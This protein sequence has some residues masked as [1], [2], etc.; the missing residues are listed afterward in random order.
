[1]IGVE[2]PMKAPYLGTPKIVAPI[3]TLISTSHFPAFAQAMLI[4]KGAVW[5]YL[6]NGRMTKSPRLQSLRIVA[7]VILL[8]FA[9]KLQS[10]AQSISIDS[11]TNG[12]VIA[13]TDVTISGTATPSGG[14]SV[15]FV[16]AF[17]NG[18]KVGNSTTAMFNIVWHNV[19]PGSYTLTARM[20]DSSGLLAT[21]GP[22]NITVLDRSPPLASYNPVTNSIVRDLTLINVTFNKAVIGVDASD[23]LIDGEAATSV[24][25]NDP[26]DFTFYFPLPATGIVQV[27]WAPDNGITDTTPLANAFGGGSWTYL[28]D[29]NLGPAN[30]LMTEFMADNATGIKDDDGNHSDWLELFNAGVFPAMLDGWFLTDTP[31]NLTKWQFPAGTPP[32]QNNSYLVVWASA[33]NRTNPLAAL[34]TNFKLAREAGSYL[35]LVDPNTNVVSAFNPY[36]LQQPDISYGRDVVDPNLVG[37]FTNSTPGKPNA[38]TGGG[39]SPDVLFSVDSG[40]YTNETLT[41]TLSVSNADDGTTIRYTVD[42]SVPTT[43]S[44]VYSGPIVFGT[45][46]II[47]ARAFPPA[48]TNLWPSQVIARNY[49]FLDSTDSTFNSN[50]PLLI[51]TTQGQIIPNGIVPGGTRPEGTL[52]IFD[53]HQGRS[54][55]GSTPDFIGTAGVEAYG[56]TSVGF[57]KP[58]IRIE[59]HDALANDSNASLL[60]M[61][62]A[63]DWKL[64]NPFDDKTLMNDFLGYELFEKM[65]HYSCRRRFVEVFI[66]TPSVSGSAYTD[67]NRTGRLRYPDDYAGVEMLV[68]TIAIDKDRVDLPKITPFNTSEPSITGGWIIKKDKDSTGDIN[69]ST[70]GTNGFPAEALKIHEPKVNSLRTPAFQGVTTSWPGP[71][72]TASASNQLSYILNYLNQLEKALYAS[73]WLSS[74]VVGTTNHWSNYLDA[75][76]WVDFHWVVEFSKQIDGIRLSDYFHKDR[77]GKIEAGPVWDWN[78]SFGNGNYLRGGQTDAWYYA[79]QDEGITANEHIWLRRL[80][81]GAA[82]MGTGNTPGTGGDP[83]FNQKI[84]DRW[85]VLRTNILNGTNVAH[86]IDELAGLLNEAAA[87]DLWGKWRSQIVG[88]YQWPNPDGAVNGTAGTYYVGANRITRNWD[89]DFQHPTNYLGDATNSIIGQMKKWVLGRYLWIDS[90]FT[91]APAFSAPDGL[92]TNGFSVTVTPPTGGTVYYTLDGTDPRAPGGGVAPGAFTNN[93]PTNLTINSDA[94][95]FARARSTNSWYNTWSPPAAVSLFTAVPS[96]RITE[97]MYHPAAPPAG[98][99]YSTE[100]FEYIEVKNI[101]AMPLNVNRFTLG[102][103]VQFAFPNVMLTAGQSAVLVANIAAFQSRYG[104][105]PLILGTYTGNLNNGGDHLTLS[106]GLQ[107]SVLDFSYNDGW[108]PATDGLGF[109]LTIVDQNAPVSSWDSAANWRAS[110]G[111]GGS[112]GQDDPAPPVLPVVLVNEVLTHEDPPAGDAIELYNSSTNQ[113][114][115][116]G[117][118]LTDNFNSPQKYTIPANTTIPAGGYVVFYA[119]N[120]FGANGTN[121]FGLGAGGDQVYLFSANG[122]DLTGYAHGVN[123]GTAAKDVTFG[124]YVISTGKEHFVAQVSST[125][126]GPNAGPLVGPIVISEINYHPPDSVI[127]NVGLNDFT[128]EFIELQNITSSPVP[129]DDMTNTWHLRNAVDYQFPLGVVLPAGGFLLVVGF[130][131]N[132]DATATANFRVRNS[133]PADLPLYGPWQQSLDNGGAAIELAGPDVP[134]TNGVPYVLVDRVEYSDSAPWPFAADGYGPTLQR[135]VPGSYGNDPANWMA[136]TAT[137]GANYAPAGTPPTITDQP[138]NRSV[139]LGTD[140]FLSA[141]ATGTAPLH[142][143]W[144]FNGINLPGATNSILP[145]MNFQFSQFGVY[146]IFV[147]NSAGTA[148]GTNFNVAGRVQLIILTQPTNTL[149]R[150]T[151]TTNLT[152]VANGTGTLRYR[153]RY[154]GIDVPNGTNA[155][156]TITNAS[157]ANTGNYDCVVSDDYNTTTTQVAALIS[158]VGPGFTIHPVSQAAVAGSTVTFTVAATGIPAPGFRWRRTGVS[159]LTNGNFNG[160]LVTITNYSFLTITNVNAANASTYSVIVTNLLGLATNGPQNGLSSNAVLTVLADTDG[161]GL[162]DTFQTANPGVIGTGDEDHDG[163]S[164][165]AE[166]FAGTDIFDPMSNLKAFLLPGSTNV[167]FIA[168]SNRTYTV[169]YTDGLSP[170]QWKKLGDVLARTFTRVES[171]PDPNPRTNRL[172]RIITPIQP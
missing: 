86:R 4:P 31:T 94:R 124:R 52:I 7:L 98:S 54:S 155:V 11:P 30:F 118:F 24:V 1:M 122:T 141:A 136:N 55:V 140:A 42:A 150:L 81:N 100:D 62:A 167:Q 158:M 171:V 69:L 148:S 128:D 70:S 22:V 170:T 37:Y 143:Q 169:Q 85:S 117:W 10:G 56:Q 139:G 39:F 109:S 95:I 44:P 129:L 96:L 151:G 116:S 82:D 5:K 112:P 59:I 14:S 130:D 93:S 107:Q 160:Y 2:N 105:G 46:V 115:I 33:K 156:L 88:V 145:L 121:S 27:A 144:R 103:G 114:D 165:A 47:K 91:R 49:V 8:F 125:L 61:P 43:N 80:I 25:T 110:S 16:E 132:A 73:N 21:S 78:L 131:P 104:S 87:R 102:G 40:I 75:D 9:G 84:V 60:G 53:T 68:E 72:Y 58:P 108:Y 147:Q 63:N 92:V 13:S 99:P 152:I 64:R 142:Y 154:N 71:G 50:L 18:P 134:T 89:I 133:V 126:G 34:H 159:A 123:F 157:S 111:L 83:D 164:N 17:A 76:S 12:Q 38:T 97:I 15:T 168:V 32:L 135:L 161:D 41:L 66:N 166:Y 127:N 153:W 28:L 19:S 146:N 119:T 57:N 67:T 101:G 6:D 149:V 48:T 20:I 106:G 65:G 45:N 35:A 137:P 29:T 51:I 113:A 79:E 120:S 163:M 90:Q 172:Y 26:N 162:P 77:G 36:P 23:L 3:T 138:G 74:S